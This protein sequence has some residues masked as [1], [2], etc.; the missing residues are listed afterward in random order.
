MS[1]NYDSWGKPFTTA[2]EKASS[3][4]VTDDEITGTLASTVG[5]KNSYRYRGYRY[6]T[7]TGMY[8]LQSRYYNPDWGRFINADAIIGQT[9]EL[10]G[11]NIFAYCKNNPVNME[12]PSGFKANWGRIFKGGFSITLGIACVVGVVVSAPATLP[13]LV[14]AAVVGAYAL[15]T[16]VQGLQDVGAGALG[17]NNYKTMNYLGE[18]VAFAIRSAHRG[19]IQL[20]RGKYSAYA[21]ALDTEIGMTVCNVSDM[22]LSGKSV[23]SK[24]TKLKKAK[25]FVSAG[26]D[27]A[28]IKMGISDMSGDSGW[29]WD[30]D[31]YTDGIHN[32]RDEYYYSGRRVYGHGPLEY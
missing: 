32:F 28:S 16:G 15:N 13:A 18:G 17:A 2:E 9:G 19:V 6:D 24:V 10:L 30:G 14:G 3:T 1:Y 20:K 12:D 25:D 22:V 11:H 4:D 29:K 5:V 21:Q 26:G 7:E 31:F 23:L 27:I 8:Y